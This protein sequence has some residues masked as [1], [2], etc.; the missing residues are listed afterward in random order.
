MADIVKEILQ[1]DAGKDA[2]DR[3]KMLIFCAWP[4]LWPVLE[5]YLAFEGVPVMLMWSNA[6][7]NVKSAQIAQ[8]QLPGPHR[9]SQGEES[10]VAVMSTSLS[11]GV[12]LTRASVL[13]GVVCYRTAE[14][15]QTFKILLGCTL[16]SPGSN[17]NSRTRLPNRTNE[18]L[19]NI[20]TNCPGYG[21]S[22]AAFLVP[23]QRGIN[24]AIH[25]R[26]P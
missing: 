3:R 26:G 10:W 13:V 23:N 2:S 14:S 9:S 25:Y 21:G 16:V 17:A 22:R 24:G 6:Q 12:T 15:H 18:A 11:V 19:P 8:F 4:S 20:S 7:E 1:E 5:A